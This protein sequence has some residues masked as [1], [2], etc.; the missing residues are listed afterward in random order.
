H[1]RRAASRRRHVVSGAAA[2][3]PQE[4]G[5]RGV[6]HDR[7]ESPRALLHADAGGPEA[8]CGGGP[9]FRAGDGRNLSGHRTGGAE[10]GMAAFFR[11]VT[12]WWRR[13]AIDAEL[14]EEIRTHLDMK[15]SDVGGPSPA[16]RAFGNPAIVLEDARS[17]WGWPRLEAFWHDLRYGTR[18]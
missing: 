15:A 2:H 11:K 6:A 14:E 16:R 12:G 10:A 17:V 3:A 8:A 4:L 5:P 18:M 7:E 1:W 13:D 9:R